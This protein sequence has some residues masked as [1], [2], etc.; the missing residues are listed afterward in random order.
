MH[1][2]FIFVVHKR[3]TGVFHSKGP[4]YCVLDIP[5][6]ELVIR[7]LPD[8]FDAKCV[9]LSN[10]LMLGST[11]AVLPFTEFKVLY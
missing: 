5:A 6:L 2:V 7:D 9:G 8:L 1:L 11:M 3:S 4:A 10:D